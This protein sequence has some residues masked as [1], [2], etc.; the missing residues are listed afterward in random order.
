[1]L[2]GD[3]TEKTQQITVMSFMGNQVKLDVRDSRF[4]TTVFLVILSTKCT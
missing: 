1:M 4:S 2:T 3:N